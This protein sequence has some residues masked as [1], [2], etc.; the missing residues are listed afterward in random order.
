MNAQIKKLLEAKT[1]VITSYTISDDSV[2]A[3]MRLSASWQIKYPVDFIKYPR[4]LSMEGNPL[5]T[6]IGKIDYQ[7]YKLK[8]LSLQNISNTIK[9]NSRTKTGTEQRAE[10]KKQW[11]KETDKLFLADYRMTT[12]KGALN[13]LKKEIEVL[14]NRQKILLPQLRRANSEYLSQKKADK[15]EQAERNANALQSGKFWEADQDALKGYFHPPFDKNYLADVSERWRAALFLECEL[16]SW[17]DYKNNW[18]HKLSGTGMGYLCG[19]DDNGDEWGHQVDGIWL[20]RDHYD[21]QAL[22]ATVEDAMTILFDIPAT[23]LHK[24][25]RQG[26][27]L[28][29]PVE[30]IP[31]NITMTS[32]AEWEIREFHTVTSETLERNGRYIRSSTDIIITHTSHPSITLS[33]GSYYLYWSDIKNAD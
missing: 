21:N 14:Q 10:A 24:C 23:E 22:N 8:S 6:E 17:K 13:R 12:R 30:A 19:I 25:S 16:V 9:I 5:W 29:C 4:E 7:L 18:K 28:F 1:P 26:D 31:E 27:L 32:V 11:I 33:S 15:T 20:K 2:Q 3:E